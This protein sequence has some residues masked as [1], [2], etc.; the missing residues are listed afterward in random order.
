M[1]SGLLAAGVA[2][3][4]LVGALP[5]AAQE[6]RYHVLYDV[7]LVPTEKV[8][9]V[10][11]QLGD[12][13][14]QLRRIRFKIDPERHRD[15]EGSGEVAVEGS[16][17]EWTPPSVGGSLR[18]RF[19]IDHLRDRRSYDSR[20]AA[21]WALFRG[22]DLVPPARVVT[23]VG[24]LSRSRLRLR[25]PEGWSVAVPY[26][27]AADGTFTLDHPDRGFDRPIGW[28]VAGKLGV[29]RE[30]IAGTRVSVAGPTRQGLRRL[31]L[32]A[33]LRWTLPELRDALGT[34]P[35][36]LLVVGAG[37]PMW[38]GGLSG[39]NSLYVHAAR[40]LISS[41]GTSPLLHELVHSV[42]RAR[43]AADAD[44]IIEGLAEYYSLQLLVRSRTVSRRRYQKTLARLTARGERASKLRI[45]EASGATTARAV[46]VL[47]RLNGAIEK[48]S[49]GENDLD[50]VLRALLEE[51]S[52]I[53]TERFR[54]LAEQAA[55][56]SLKSFFER[57]VP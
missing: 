26:A 24:A 25:L 46:A 34:L 53:T 11:I 41:D 22:D 56:R 33:L 30:R 29:V 17:V 49:D 57:Y 9:R 21:N 23:R 16:E 36:R 3:A 35:E 39:P 48:A 55:G 52:P 10:S 43:P 27:R 4:L 13:A 8:A 18:Y 19:R 28:F 5:T 2:T 51:R 32:L 15:F 40:P 45:A 50:D 47:D 38:R 12:G 6:T 54:V 1:R 7:R 42:L 20:C 14:Q 44:W 37:D 31:D